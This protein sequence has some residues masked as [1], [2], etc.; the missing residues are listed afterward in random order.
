MIVTWE[1][2]L[3]ILK[4]LDHNSHIKFALMTIKL[5]ENT[6]E[7]SEVVKNV[8]RL[9]EDWIESPNS[10][11]WNSLN[12]LSKDLMA[13]IDLNKSYAISCAV[14]CVVFTVCQVYD[15]DFCLNSSYSNY[16]GSINA[17]FVAEL[18]IQSLA[19]SEEAK[20]QI[21]TYLRELYLESL[22]EEERNSWLVQAIIGV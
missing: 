10:L 19:D 6:S 3:E 14:S 17:R 4:Q 22:P 21:V 13:N 8:I 15:A 1:N 16:S 11:T 12:K 5:I 9:T 7:L 2:K 18:T 20:R